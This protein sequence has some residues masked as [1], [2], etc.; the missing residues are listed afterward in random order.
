MWVFELKTLFVSVETWT[1][2]CKWKLLNGILEM[3]YLLYFSA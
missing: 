1:I 2:I 3:E